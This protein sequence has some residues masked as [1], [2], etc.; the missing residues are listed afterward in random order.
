LRSQDTEG[1]AGMNLLGEPAAR[2]YLDGRLSIRRAQVQSVGSSF[3]GPTDFQL[4]E[5]L[6]DD[7]FV[8]IRDEWARVRDDAYIT[9]TPLEWQPR[10]IATQSIQTVE[11]NRVP[12]FMRRIAFD[13][14]A[15]LILDDPSPERKLIL[16]TFGR[17]LPAVSIGFDGGA[18]SS[19]TLILTHCLTKDGCSSKSPG[20]CNCSIVRVVTGDGD[21]AWACL[22]DRHGSA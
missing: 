1:R 3:V 9:L 10:G 16:A 5:Y 14:G 17:E 13:W 7:S 8:G 15:A 4:E 19:F 11:A 21:D 6:G 22:C 18:A 12:M 2:A 20:R